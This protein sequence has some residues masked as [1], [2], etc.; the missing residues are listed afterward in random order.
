ME[1][2]KY[3]CL[4]GGGAYLLSS[5]L[6]LVN[7]IKQYRRRMAATNRARPVPTEEIPLQ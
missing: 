7:C 4:A 2:G 5:L 3:M 1:I 6:H